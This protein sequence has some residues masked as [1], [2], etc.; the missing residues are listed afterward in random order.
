MSGDARFRCSTLLAL[1]A[2]SSAAVAAPDSPYPE[3]AR[4]G[5]SAFRNGLKERGLTDLLALHLREHPPND[6]V[7][8]GLLAR[9]VKLTESADPSRSAAKRAAALTEANRLL[10]A[11]IE[12]HSADA[13]VREWQMELAQSLLHVEAEAP[14]SSILYRGGTPVDRQALAAVMERAVRV[15]QDLHAFSSLE[16]DALDQLPAREYDRREASGQIERL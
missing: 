11:L 6:A 2:F 8:A 1:A 16:Y 13:R 15:L 5:E 7:E 14:I 9:D 12:E 4:F 10:D 3:G